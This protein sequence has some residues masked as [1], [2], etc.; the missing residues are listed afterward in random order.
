MD[1]SGNIY[2]AGEFYNGGNPN[3]A[4]IKL[5]SSGVLQWQKYS[6]ETTYQAYNKIFVD[7]SGNSYATALGATWPSFVKYNSSGVMQFQKAINITSQQKFNITADSSGNIYFVISDYTG[8]SDAPVIVKLNSSGVIQWQQYTGLVSDFST[9]EVGGAVTDTSGNI[10]LTAISSS[11]TK[12]ENCMYIMKY[13]SSGASQWINK[14]TSG[15]SVN[16]PST[17]IIDSSGNIYFSVFNSFS[18]ILIYKINSAG[19]VQ[20][21]NEINPALPSSIF[22]NGDT[23]VKLAV[24]TSSLYIFANYSDGSTYQTFTGQVPIDGT[25]TGVYY[26]NNTPFVYSASN[27]TFLTVVGSIATTAYTISNT[28][29]SDLAFTPT[30]YT[31]HNTATYPVNLSSVKSDV[32]FVSGGELSSDATYYYRKFVNSESLYI[33]SPTSISFDAYIVG[34]GGAGG[35]TWYSNNSGGGGGGAGGVLTTTFSSATAQL[36]ITVGAGGGYLP[37]YGGEGS[38]INGVTTTGGGYGGYSDSTHTSGVA[39]GN[40]GSGGGGGGI[41]GTNSTLSTG[42]SGQGFRGGQSTYAGL[43][44]F[45]YAVNSG[46]AGGGGA[47][48]VGSNGGAPSTTSYSGAGNGGAGGA[49][50]SGI[51]VWTTANY[52]GG[53]GNGGANL[54]Y[55]PSYGYFSST[56]ANPAVPVGGGGSGLDNS[57]GSISYIIYPNNGGEGTGGGGGGG[58]SS[59]DNGTSS[60]VLTYGGAGGSGVVWI[61]YLRSAVGG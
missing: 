32:K 29:G 50:G 33:N 54:A 23:P 45:S 59:A 40:G 19:V 53:G 48:S 24:D 44:S 25:G 28:T 17:P 5:N 61:R 27:S 10:Y 1:A 16:N 43:N 11:E 7:G 6:T 38:S 52:V 42:I 56:V 41:S 12:S 47:A 36:L 3:A 14:I 21:Q 46:G 37:G 20:W 55:S 18:K 57:G 60:A 31:F 9:L 2:L 13:N 34:G 15:E 35:Y 4:I 51:Q 58:G 49:G 30:T 8:T 26:L 39:P 22:Y